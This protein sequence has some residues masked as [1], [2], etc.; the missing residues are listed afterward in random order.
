MADQELDQVSGAAEVGEG[1]LQGSFEPGKSNTEALSET[2][3]RF[4]ETEMLAVSR[5]GYLDDEGTPVE[6][7]TENEC[8]VLI[9]PSGKRAV[10]VKPFL[11]QYRKFPERK[12]GLATLTDV[13]SFVEHVKRTATGETVIFGDQ[14][15][16]LAKLIAVYD[17]NK[18]EADKGLAR[19]MEHCAEYRFPHSDEW[20]AWHGRQGEKNIMPMKAF[21]E[22]IEDRIMDVVDPT[23][24]TPKEWEGSIGQRMQEQ[25]GIT[26]ATP[27]RLVSISRSLS[28]N[29]NNAFEESVDLD[30]GVKNFTFKETRTGSFGAPVE[31][32]SA[33]LIRIP[34]FRGDK[35][36]VIPV[37]FRH[38]VIDG[39]VH[40]FYTVY[41]MDLHYLESV[42]R[43]CDK[44]KHDTGRPLLMGLPEI[45][46]TIGR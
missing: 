29:V 22:F 33:F 20:I 26:Y 28:I 9:L 44:V 35:P 12:T 5:E 3:A 25:L 10:S 16:N 13:D 39:K 7:P 38:R 24:A 31:I 11:D 15:L 46:A 1:L 36:W 23:K 37:Q 41:R 2:F 45:R 14:T 43:T 18:P 8:H 17:Y 19:H 32:E 42:K 40:F 34:V 30:N 27:S 21:A 4:H 6:A